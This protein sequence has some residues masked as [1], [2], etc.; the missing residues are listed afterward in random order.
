MEASLGC[1]IFHNHNRLISCSIHIRQSTTPKKK[2]D[3]IYCWRLEIAQFEYSIKY[4]PGEENVAANTL[5]RLSCA[6]KQEPVSLK[7]FHKQM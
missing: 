4:P 6:T 3:K 7:L 5:T 1:T 2:N